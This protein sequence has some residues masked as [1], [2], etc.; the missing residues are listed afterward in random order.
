MTELLYLLS[1]EQQQERFLCY[2]LKKGI[3]TT[4]ISE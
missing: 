3:N 2:M 1:L 4:K